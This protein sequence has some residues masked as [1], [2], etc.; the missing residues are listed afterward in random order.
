[1]VTPSPHR[2]QFWGWR[3]ILAAAAVRHSISAHRKSICVSGLE[4][5]AETRINHGLSTVYYNRKIK[6]IKLE[7]SYDHPRKSARIHSFA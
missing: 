2:L 6:L 5:Q 4:A 3:L 7:L 1:M